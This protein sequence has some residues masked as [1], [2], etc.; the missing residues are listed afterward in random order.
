MYQTKR[1]YCEELFPN[2]DGLAVVYGSPKG[3][4]KYLKLPMSTYIYK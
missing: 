2:H 1:G 3:P 4:N